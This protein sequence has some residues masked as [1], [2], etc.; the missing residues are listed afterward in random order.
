MATFEVPSLWR[1]APIRNYVAAGFARHSGA[2]PGG[3]FRAAVASDLNGGVLTH[4]LP[5]R[6]VASLGQA[7]RR[8]VLGEH[9]GLGGAIASSGKQPNESI[10]GGRDAEMA[11]HPLGVRPD[12]TGTLNLI[13][14]GDGSDA[15]PGIVTVARA[16]AAGIAL[17][18]E[19]A[20]G[21]VAGLDEA[22]V[23]AL[24]QEGGQAESGAALKRGG[25]A[26]I[27][28]CARPIGIAPVFKACAGRAPSGLPLALTP[29]T[30][31]SR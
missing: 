31:F 1:R 19:T 15:V 27:P 4:Q 30:G 12:R 11:D 18:D 26:E 21:V 22:G 10:V 23:W 25:S 17:L 9:L 16:L 3:C 5:Q 13:A 20:G 24:Q 29:P 28:D 7:R 14:T 8:A 2:A 6:M